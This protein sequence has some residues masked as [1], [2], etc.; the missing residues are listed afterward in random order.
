MN[1]EISKPEVNKDNQNWACPIERVH[2]RGCINKK[3]LG[4]GVGNMCHDFDFYTT[5]ENADK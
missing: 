2:N 1:S 3:S 5:E 4:C